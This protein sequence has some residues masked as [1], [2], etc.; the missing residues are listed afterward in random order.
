MF[1]DF[2]EIEGG[3]TRE[4]VRQEIR[5][6]REKAKGLNLD[7]KIEV[8]CFLLDMPDV[9]Y[10]KIEGISQSEIKKIVTEPF[11]YFNGI[12]DAPS[13]SMQEGTILHLLLNEP[14][15]LDEKVFITDAERVTK[16]IKEEAGDRILIKE[17]ELL[18]LQD[19]ASYT[20]EFLKNTLRLDVEEMDGEVSYFGE[21]NG[22]KA[23]GRADRISKDRKICLDFKKTANASPKEFTRQATNLKY[24]IQDVFYRELMGLDEFLWIAIE[25][26]PLVDRLGKNHFMIGVYRSSDLMK[27]QGKKWIDL[28]F[29]I[30]E[31]KEIFNAPIYPSENL[32]DDLQF[33]MSIVR[34][35]T[36]P[37]WNLI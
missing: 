19:C 8:G 36:P 20:K 2:S 30:L 35:I 27:E 1:V 4:Q 3:V 24:A 34:E 9:E 12:H 33:G 11:K 26:K 37:L 18:I 17:K 16:A 15:L 22:V 13:A 10:R 32:Q 14:H 29:K 7:T 25:T 6:L 28:A 5:G 21:Y 31:E 23:K